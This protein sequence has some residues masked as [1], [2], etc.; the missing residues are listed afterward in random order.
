[1]IFESDLRRTQRYSSIAGISV[2]GFEGKALLKDISNTGFC[3]ESAT[4]VNMSP[5]EQYTVK[6]IPEPDT[7]VKP[8]DVVVEVR[9]VRSTEDKFE[10]GM[11]II[12]PPLGQAFDLY[13]K[14]L[15]NSM[16]R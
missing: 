6:I 10:T 12:K 14:A 1:M 4:C 2:N 8:F 15:K 13:L 9:W 16:H 5:R 3:L 11:N 7:G